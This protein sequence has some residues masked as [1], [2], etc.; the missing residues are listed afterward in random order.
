MLMRDCVLSYS[1]FGLISEGSEVKAIEN[2]QKSESLVLT[3]TT[4]LHRVAHYLLKK[5]AHIS[6]EV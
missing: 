1:T 5:D 4:S 2:T 6:D 3:T